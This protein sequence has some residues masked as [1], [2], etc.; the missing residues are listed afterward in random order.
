M[1]TLIEDKKNFLASYACDSYVSNGMR[2]GLGTGSTVAYFLK[3]LSQRINDLHDCTFFVTSEDTLHRCTALQLPVCSLEQIEPNDVCLDLTVDGADQIDARGAMIKGG[4][5]ALLREKILAQVS[6]EYLIL[7]TDEKEIDSLT[8]PLPVEVPPY[9]VTIAIDSL[10]KLVGCEKKA[11]TL[12]RG[13]R[14]FGPART[15]NAAV[16]LDIQYDTIKD[17]KRLATLL[18]NEPYVL[19]HGLFVERSYT[20]LVHNGTNTEARKISW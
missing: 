13:D 12:R 15:E 20:Y 19:A 16:I 14:I 4:G 1:S 5:G 8:V 10:S 11:I 2:I 18:S 9:S 3:A 6:T 7:I 17:P